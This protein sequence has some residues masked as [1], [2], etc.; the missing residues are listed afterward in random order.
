MNSSTFVVRL[1]KTRE[2]VIHAMAKYC[3]APVRRAQLKAN[4][5]AR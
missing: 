1:W 3:R 2:E 5:K 4:K